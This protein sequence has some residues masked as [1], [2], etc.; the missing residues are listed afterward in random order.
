VRGRER[1]AL[2]LAREFCAIFRP[3]QS[4]ALLARSPAWVNAHTDQ[5][6][7]AGSLILGLWL[8]GNSIYLIVT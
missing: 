2:D 5:A 3:D 4:Q 6:I 1:E 7:I 8:M